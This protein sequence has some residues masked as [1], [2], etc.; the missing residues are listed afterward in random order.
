MNERYAPVVG[1]DRNRSQFMRIFC[2]F[3]DDIGNQS[4]AK[5]IESRIRHPFIVFLKILSLQRHGS[6]AQIALIV[7][8]NRM[9]RMTGFGQTPIYSENAISGETG[10]EAEEREMPPSHAV[11]YR[12]GAEPGCGSSADDHF[13]W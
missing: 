5:R 3:P 11:E 1:L 12:N 10:I 13:P 4:F 7:K 2:P 8:A 6:V 9:Q